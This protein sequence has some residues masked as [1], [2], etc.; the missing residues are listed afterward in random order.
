MLVSFGYPLMAPVPSSTAKDFMAVPPLAA[1]LAAASEYV[2]CVPED[3]E[4]TGKEP[5]KPVPVT[6]AMIT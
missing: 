3:V 1:P 5:L 4:A 6:P 2:N